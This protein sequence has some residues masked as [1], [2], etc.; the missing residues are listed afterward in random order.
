[1]LLG[2][3]ASAAGQ[4]RGVDSVE[5]MAADS[6][7]IVR[8]RFLDY[9]REGLEPLRHWW[10]LT[11]TVTET[12]RGPYAP[13]ETVTIV[14]P[15]R[16]EG[17]IAESWPTLN[18]ERL[19]FLA[20][21]EPL[22]DE[23]GRAVET[24]F[25]HAPRAGTWALSAQP[26]VGPVAFTMDFS[27]VGSWEAL[28]EVVRRAAVHKAVPL[29]RD[30]GSFGEMMYFAF[31]AANDRVVKLWAPPESDL[32]R[33]QL[34][35]PVGRGSPLHSYLLVPADDRL[36]Q[37]AERWAREGPYKAQALDVL[38]YYQSP[39]TNRALE[40]LLDDPAY[41]GFGDG[42]AAAWWHPVRAAAY[43]VLRRRGVPVPRAEI[44][45]PHDARRP[46]SAARIAAVAAFAGSALLAASAL[47]AL[48]SRRRRRGTTEPASLPSEPAGV[49]RWAWRCV[50][51]L[52]A[53]GTLGCLLV[54][55]RSYRRVDEIAYSTRQAR[56][57]VSSYRGCLQVV[58][59]RNWPEAMPPSYA[60]FDLA[61]SSASPWEGG[62]VV[63]AKKVGWGSFRHVD[64]TQTARP[65]LPPSQYQSFYAPLW[66]VLLPVGLVPVIAA[67]RLF[68]GRLRSR[69]WRRQ[70]RCAA[71]GYDLRGNARPERCPECGGLTASPRRLA[72][73][74]KLAARRSGCC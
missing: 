70:R 51:L 20:N 62:G 42:K 13:G 64:G 39:R 8:A 3:Q 28:C 21:C 34:A 26:G 2:L 16:V 32:Y 49:L 18:E 73:S 48:V 46:L 29:K 61:A 1:L 14:V 52:L 63:V 45:M 4:I 9:S 10:T 15:S 6:D 43:P 65:G 35:P 17:R 11:V 60:T 25:R 36:E 47:G 53:L 41:E 19:L 59:L 44:R 24:R 22:R 74:E 23:H 40:R 72:P 27:R 30:P 58:L 54:I 56:Y 68:G 69:R 12:I 57:W 37:L 55:V 5:W 50:V 71:C 66:A 33:A 67:L 7:V 31:A 38:R